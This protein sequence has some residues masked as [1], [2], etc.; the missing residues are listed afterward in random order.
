VPLTPLDFII[1]IGLLLWDLWNLRDDIDAQLKKEA[2]E[3]VVKQKKAEIESEIKYKILDNPSTQARYMRQWEED[4]SFSGFLYARVSAEMIS[5]DGGPA[6]VQK[7]TVSDTST[8]H[9]T[10]LTSKQYPQVKMVT[11][12]LQWTMYP[13]F[14]TPFDIVLIKVTNLF[15]DTLYFVG[16]FNDASEWYMQL[17]NQMGGIHYTETYEDQ[18]G[19]AIEFRSPLVALRCRYCLKYLHWAAGRLSHHPLVEEDLEG[20]LENP[21]KGWRRRHGIL[22]KL[23]EGQGS[24]RNYRNN[25]AWFADTFKGLVAEASQTPETRDAIMALYLGARSIWDDLQRIERNLWKPEYFYYGPN[26]EPRK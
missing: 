4:R 25:F 20:N 15:V 13:P 10:T 1:E 16:F 22:V 9:G 21:M 24:G 3:K 5:D 7:V 17:F 2:F 8:R 19:D 23:L 12:I 26:F 11:S 14:M 6:F 18:F